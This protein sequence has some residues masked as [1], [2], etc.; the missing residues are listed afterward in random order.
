VPDRIEIGLKAEKTEIARDEAT[1]VDVDGKFLYARRLL[2]SRWKARSSSPPRR[3]GTASRILLSA[4]LMK[5]KATAR[6]SRSK[7]F[8]SLART[9]P[10]KCRSRSTPCPRRRLI[11]AGVTV[12][13]REG[14]GRAVERSVDIA[15]KPATDMIGV[16][17]EFDDGAV[18]EGSAATFR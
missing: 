15:I 3:P 18:S 6:R 12:R 11:N 10:P 9:A 14:A 8:L 5:S 1:D 13:M 4:W 16:K 17:A 2:G 7:T